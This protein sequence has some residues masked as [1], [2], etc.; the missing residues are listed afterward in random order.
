MV[1]GLYTGYTGMVNEQ[2]RLDV[3]ANNLAKFRD[4]RVQKRRYGKSV[5]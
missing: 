4:D 3:I 1:K 5:F 2:K